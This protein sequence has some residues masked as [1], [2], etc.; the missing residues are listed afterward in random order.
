MADY[1]RELHEH[2]QAVIETIK[3]ATWYHDQDPNS[4]LDDQ[5]ER[6]LSAA[7]DA[8]SEPLPKRAPY[9]G[10]HRYLIPK[11]PYS[12][13]YTYPNDDIVVVLAVVHQRQRP[14]QWT[15]RLES[16]WLDQFRC[17]G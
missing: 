1:R 17:E 5:F 6:Q 12:V 15:Q 4:D 16:S 14:G 10:A 8:L 3:I 13:I 7:Y 11:W 9:L 2:P